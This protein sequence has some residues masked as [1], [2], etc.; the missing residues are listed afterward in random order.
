D[1]AD[2]GA[3]RLQ[4]RPPLRPHRAALHARRA[5]DH[6]GGAGSDAPRARALGPRQVAR[7]HAH[8]RAAL[9]AGPHPA[10]LS[11]APRTSGRPGAPTDVVVLTTGART[12]APQA[13]YPRTAP[14]TRRHFRTPARIARASNP[15]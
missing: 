8:L 5:G 12:D 4:R 10:E 9:H 3:V 1:G 15:A 13:P 7:A 14:R 11:A 2:G 6:G